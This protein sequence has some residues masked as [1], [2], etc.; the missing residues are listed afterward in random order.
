[1]K[2]TTDPAAP[3]GTP[4]VRVAVYRRIEELEP[5]AAAWDRLVFADTGRLPMSSHAWVASYLAERH[6]AARRWMCLAAFAGDR[7]EGVWPIEVEEIRILGRRL[8][9]LR[10]P[11]DSHMQSVE[12]VVRPGRERAVLTAL[13]A[14]LDDAAPAWF[15]LNFDHLEEGAPLAGEAARALTRTTLL[16]EG[17]NYASVVKCTGDWDEYLAGLGRNFRKHL[18]KEHRRLAEIG[19]VR[20]EFLAGPQA[21][22]ELLRRFARIE[23]AGWKGKRGTAISS[24]ENL[25]AFYRA[26][27]RRLAERGALEWHFLRAGGHDLAGHFA[28]RTGKALVIQ[29]IGYDEAFAAYSPGVVL[30]ERALERAFADAA[31]AEVNLVTDRAWHDAWHPEKRPYIQVRMYPRRVRSL[32]AGAW[33]H[34]VR[35]ALR[36]VRPLRRAV[37]WWRSRRTGPGAD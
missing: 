23:A 32:V 17:S 24:R 7:L 11:W 2:E 36:R 37:G 31:T 13:R 21:D 12:A 22:P 15:G 30:M 28:I 27:C 4:G 14:A 18:R 6:P 1:M 26:L 8:P 19:E 5:L 25:T 35:L 33:P 3:A 16:C 9:M 29:K 20:T 10:Q 34:R